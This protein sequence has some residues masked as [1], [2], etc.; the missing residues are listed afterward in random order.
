MYLLEDFINDF[1]KCPECGGK[2]YI[3]GTETECSSFEN[4][5]VS[6]KVKCLVCGKKLESCLPSVSFKELI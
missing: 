3:D 6:V 1:Y 2:L 5:Y 4:D